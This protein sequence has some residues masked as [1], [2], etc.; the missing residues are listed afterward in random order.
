MEPVEVQMMSPLLKRDDNRVSYTVD[1]EE[2]PA[3]WIGSIDLRV[4]LYSRSDKAKYVSH[5]LDNGARKTHKVFRN[6]L[7]GGRGLDTQGGSISESEGGG[8]RVLRSSGA[9]VGA[10][11]TGEGVRQSHRPSTLNTYFP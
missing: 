6:G 8:T 7:V 2:P 3:L 4:A 10:V 5:C 1:I 9:P 11:S